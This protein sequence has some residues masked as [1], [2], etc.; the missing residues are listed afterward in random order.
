MPSEDE[1]PVTQEGVPPD[2][3][4]G[5]STQPSAD[6][7]SSLDQALDDAGIGV[8]APPLE[9]KPPEVVPDEK[10]PLEEAKPPGEV[11]PEEKPLEVTPK[12]EDDAAKKT[13]ELE[14]LDL[15]AVALPKTVSPKNAV[16]FDKLR[17]VAKHYKSQAA[18]V[19]VLRQ[20]LEELKKAAPAAAPEV[21]AELTELRNFRKIFD[22]EHDPEFQKQFSEKL[23][24]IDEEV[25][26]I[27][28]KNGLSAEAEASLRKIGVGNAELAWWEQTILPN[29]P[30]IDRERLQ[31]RLAARADVVDQKTAEVEKF[32]SQREAVLGERQQKLAKSFEEQQQAIEAHLETMTKDV[33]WA[34]FQEAPENA[35]AAE[36]KAVEAHNAEVTEMQKHFQDALYPQTPQARAEVAGAA[37]AS[38][39][40]AAALDSTALQLKAVAEAKDKLQKELDAVKAAGKL[41]TP[42]PS[43]RT[44]ASETADKGKLTDEDAIEAGLQEAEA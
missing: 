24:A 23:G 8:D 16:N 35:T 3:D 42:R 32:S 21:E 37:V 26:G 29:V 43:T 13:A 30:F 38:I 14:A 11:T 39:K 20:Q 12:P 9:E 28:K 7:H 31:K 15:D 2:L 33:P 18:E 34:R 19:P 17:E 36:K 4:L 40:L 41:P 22:I 25:I 1:K 27:L 5:N 10:P 6:D 44:A